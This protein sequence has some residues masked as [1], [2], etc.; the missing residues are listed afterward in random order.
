MYI[1]WSL[2]DE[3]CLFLSQRHSQILLE[4][5]RFCQKSEND[6]NSRGRGEVGGSCYLR[7]YDPMRTKI[8]G[9]SL[10]LGRKTQI[11]LKIR[12]LIFIRENIFGNKSFVEV[13][14]LFALLRQ[15]WKLYSGFY[16]QQIAISL[17]F[18]KF[19]RSYSIHIIFKVNLK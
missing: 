17:F 8:H 12:Q 7:Q 2:K 15:V 6:T 5:Y 9:S 11:G 13:E 4:K 16:C 14:I 19:F 18:H 1:R 10:I 3:I